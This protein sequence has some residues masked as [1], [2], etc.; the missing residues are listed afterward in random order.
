MYTDH[1]YVVVHKILITEINRFGDK[2]RSQ[3]LEFKL[4]DKK[5]LFSI[6]VPNTVEISHLKRGNK[7]KLQLH[8]FRRGRSYSPQFSV[9]G[10]L[11][12]Q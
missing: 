8:V 7:I 3:I 1:E 4:P 6:G 9:S 12:L 5:Q 11:L 10:V 2:W